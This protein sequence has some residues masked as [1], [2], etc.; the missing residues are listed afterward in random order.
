MARTPD[1]RAGPRSEEKLIFE[2][3]DDQGNPT[4]DPT[5]IGGMTYHDGSFAMK[6]A[7]GV[8]DPRSGGGGGLTEYTHKRLRH[9]IHFIDEGPA[10]GFASGAFKEVLP[11]GSPF[12]TSIIWWE[13]TS[14]LQKIV[15]KTIT[16]SG[17]G[18]TMCP[19]RP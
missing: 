14:K 11:A 9:L 15:E 3:V 8:F 6:D 1:R 17:G 5:E 7:I 16:R 4:V 12:P 10:D 18:A 13:S 19:R 2:Q